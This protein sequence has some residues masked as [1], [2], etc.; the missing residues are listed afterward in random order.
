MR[1]VITVVMLTAAL[2]LLGVASAFA[3]VHGITPLNCPAGTADSVPNNANAGGNGTDG[4]PADDAN[5][6]PIAGVI[7]IA[8][9]GVAFTPNDGDAGQHS[10]HCR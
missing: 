3:H 5:G 2:S 1:R 9:G 8:L 4:T 6:G 7:P 10:S